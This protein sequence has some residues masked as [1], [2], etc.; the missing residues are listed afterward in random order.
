MGRYI[1]KFVCLSIISVLVALP[2]ASRQSGDDAK[3][4]ERAARLHREAIVIDT[5]NDITSPM[6]DKGYDLGARDTS[7]QTQTDI[8]RMKEGG[9]DAEFFAIYVSGRYAREGGSARRALDMIDDVYEQARRH[10]GELEMAFTSD[11]I[12]RISKKGKIAALMGIEGG[13]AIEDSLAALRMFYRLG[14][15][16][17]TLTHSNTN[18][19][20]DSSGD[21]NNKEVKHHNGLTDFGREVVKEMN[22]IGMMV[23]IS[24]VADK[25]FWD[26]IEVSQA[27]VIASHSSARQL[28]D[29]PRNMTDDM[30]RA[31]GKKGGVVMINFGSSFVNTKYVKP[32]PE[33]QAK[34]DEARRTY[35]GDLDRMRQEIAKLTGPRPRVTLD[36]LI[37]HIAH[38]AK[39]AGIDNVGLGSD[40]DGVGGN[41]PEGMEDI[42]KLPAI[43]Y[44]LL[45]RGFSE[46]DVKKILGENFLRTMAEVERAAKRLQDAGARP[47]YA[48]ISEAGK[49]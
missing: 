25:T 13:H 36:M 38:V 10:P 31:V 14:V 5:H 1:H 27:P 40:F 18:N 16:Y 3:L 6:T 28:T 20:A 49:K 33:L 7:G 2:A 46:S 22:R 24:H 21:I 39:V 23:D 41:L 30:L 48:S 47:S 19:W 26:V 43:T 29:I 32:S 12:R 4:R 45:K 35:A 34:I 9:V 44:E 42:S 17:M 37:D 11:D 15:R 8:P